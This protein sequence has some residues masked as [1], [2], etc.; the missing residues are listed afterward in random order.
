MAQRLT[1]VF[2]DGHGPYLGLTV[3][4]E[5]E[6]PDQ[7][8]PVDFSLMVHIRQTPFFEVAFSLLGLLVITNRRKCHDSIPRR[9]LPDVSFIVV[10]VRRSVVS[11]SPTIMKC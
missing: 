5:F 8:G 10:Y 2:S 9:K 1:E 7:I 3:L 11:I 4:S 6:N